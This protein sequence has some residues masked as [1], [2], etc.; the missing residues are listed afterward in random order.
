MNGSVR[1]KNDFPIWDSRVSVSQSCSR[2]M[3]PVD[4]SVDMP[5]SSAPQIIP[6]LIIPAIIRSPMTK[7]PGSIAPTIATGTY[8]AS[9]I[10][11]APVRIVS[12]P[13]SPRFTRMIESFLL[14]GCFSQEITFPTTT[15][16]RKCSSIP[17]ISAVWIEYSCARSFIAYFCKSHWRGV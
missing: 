2:I 16:S 15:L 6:R 7:S 11:C 14:S 8:I 9:L 12:S 13:I 4:S 5:I 1:S 10:F 17:S 3:I